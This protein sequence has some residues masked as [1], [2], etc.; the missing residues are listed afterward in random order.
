MCEYKD[1]LNE[2]GK[3]LSWTGKW[4]KLS[5]FTRLFLLMSMLSFLFA[6]KTDI[7]NMDVVG[8]ILTSAAGP[9][10]A[11]SGIT[12]EDHLA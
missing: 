7:L 11:M 4:L 1:H 3:S 2:K 8:K 12:T 6:V 5:S 9:H 10:M